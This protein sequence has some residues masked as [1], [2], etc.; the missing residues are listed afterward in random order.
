MQKLQ[1]IPLLDQPNYE[2]SATNSGIAVIGIRYA[3]KAL[4]LPPIARNIRT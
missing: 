1:Q 3:I 2:S 4:M